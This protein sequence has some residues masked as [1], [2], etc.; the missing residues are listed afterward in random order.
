MSAVRGTKAKKMQAKASEQNS[1]TRKGRNK[2]G[3][4]PQHDAKK[5]GGKAGGV[6]KPGNSDGND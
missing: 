4:I 5:K 2:S 3:V 6:M 1:R